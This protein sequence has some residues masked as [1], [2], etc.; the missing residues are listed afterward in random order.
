MNLNCSNFSV[1]PGDNDIGGE[2]SEQIKPSKI[3]RFRKTFGERDTYKFDNN[4]NIYHINRIT[5]E[6]PLYNEDD[7]YELDDNSSFVRIFI[8]HMP[9]L[10]M[11]GTFTKRLWTDSSHTYHL[12][13]TSIDHWKLKASQDIWDTL[14]LILFKRAITLLSNLIWKFFG[15]TENCWKFR[16]LLAVTEWVTQISDT[17]WA[18]FEEGY[19]YYSVL[20]IPFRFHQLK[21][22]SIFFIIVAISYIITTKFFRNIFRRFSL[23]DFVKKQKG[24]K[25]FLPR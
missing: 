17:H 1:I 23:K 7:K 6:L 21:S 13:V 8:S 22:Y 20:W 9:L 4:F 12:A 11:P 19:L 25:S 15:N 5:H 18:V 16:F 10:M 2:G 3:H 24:A 14:L